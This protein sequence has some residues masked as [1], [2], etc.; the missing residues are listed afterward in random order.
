MRR[1]KRVT[2]KSV[3]V[4]ENTLNKVQETITF[5][6]TKRVLSGGGTRSLEDVLTIIT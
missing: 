6:E 2:K 4:E 3:M 5:K 1:D